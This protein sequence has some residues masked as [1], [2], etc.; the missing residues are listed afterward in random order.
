MFQD[1]DNKKGTSN[2][3]DGN[4]QLDALPYIPDNFQG[5]AEMVFDRLPKSSRVMTLLQIYLKKSQLSL[6]HNIEHPKK[7]I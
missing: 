3:I 1:T 4:V 2:I 7:M 5:V 6:A